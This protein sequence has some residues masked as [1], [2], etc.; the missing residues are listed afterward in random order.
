MKL[1]MTP[2][3]SS[4]AAH[5]ALRE[6]TIDIELVHVDLSTH[7]T[8]AGE[9]YYEINP[10]GYVPAL[11]FDDGE[12][13]T[14]VVA[15][16][17]WAAAQS[18]RLVP[19]GRLGRQRM[20]EMAAFAATE[21][22]RPF[23]RSFFSPAAAEKASARH[24]IEVRLELAANWIQQPFLF[25]DTFSASDP[26]LYLMIRWARDFGLDV[27]QRLLAYLDAVEER[28]AVR[29]AFAAEGLEISATFST[30]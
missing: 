24:A 27:P 21:L 28:A 13:L 23:M 3:A 11:V 29:A 18:P 7:R 8:S 12:T 15:I 6:A 26:L 17:D 2:G 10:K 16:L 22:H 4:L 1:Y 5:I 14:E 30:A 25:G 9:D 19:P 20:L